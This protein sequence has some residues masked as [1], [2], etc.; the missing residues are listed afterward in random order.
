MAEDQ[1]DDALNEDGMAGWGSSGENSDIDD[2]AVKKTKKV[3]DDE[4]DDGEFSI[5]DPD[6]DDELEDEEI[7]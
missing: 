4:D 1:Q 5:D 7:V 6:T 2:G 3:S